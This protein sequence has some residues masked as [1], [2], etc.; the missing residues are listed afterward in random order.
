M[1]CLRDLS[2]RQRHLL[3]SRDFAKMAL[4]VLSSLGTLCVL[5]AHKWFLLFNDASS[6]PRRRRYLRPWEDS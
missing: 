1:I 4:M 2:E 5:N 3:L 6:S